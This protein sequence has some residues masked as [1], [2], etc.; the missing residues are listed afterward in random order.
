MI[1]ALRAT[2]A[3]DMQARMERVRCNP[4]IP[5]HG[6][7]TQIAISTGSFRDSVIAGYSLG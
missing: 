1:V 7:S 2:H 5:E 6:W 4:T 3:D